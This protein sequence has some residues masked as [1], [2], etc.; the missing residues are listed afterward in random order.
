MNVVTIHDNNPL[1]DKFEGINSNEINA[2]MALLYFIEN[3]MA[4]KNNIPIPHPE[5]IGLFS[6]LFKKSGLNPREYMGGNKKL[7]GGGDDLFDVMNDLFISDEDIS[8]EDIEIPDSIRK[9]YKYK[10]KKITL[11]DIYR[12]NSY[13]LLN[14]PTNLEILNKNFSFYPEEIR[15]YLMDL[16]RQFEREQQRKFQMANLGNISKGVPGQGRPFYEGPGFQEKDYLPPAIGV[17]GGKTKKYKKN[18]TKKNKTKKR[19]SKINKNKSKKHKINKNK[20]TKKHK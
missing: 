17:R 20:I 11:F 1:T 19:K 5:L 15:V 7:I 16:N 14:M 18:K 13:L 10:N 3:R 12:I 9:Y 6:Q 4:K 8:E 2:N